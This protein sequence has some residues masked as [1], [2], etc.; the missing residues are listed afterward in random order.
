M[1]SSSTWPISGRE[2]GDDGTNWSEAVRQAVGNV[3]E[4]LADQQSSLV[5]RLTASLTCDPRV[6]RGR[7][8]VVPRRLRQ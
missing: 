2:L 3:E 6:R 1:T 7:L 4:R 5:R 8:G